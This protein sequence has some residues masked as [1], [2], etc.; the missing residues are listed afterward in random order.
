[1]GIWWKSDLSGTHTC[2]L[3]S[4]RPFVV[5]EL[6]ILLK[7]DTAIDGDA[8]FCWRENGYT[9]AMPVCFVKCMKGYRCSNTLTPGRRSGSNAIDTCHTCMKEQG[10][11][12]DRLF[13]QPPNIMMPRHSIAKSSV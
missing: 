10:S 2:V 13:M 4:F 9:I 1:M 12:S 8:H 6:A 3:F 5:M 11:N 7:A